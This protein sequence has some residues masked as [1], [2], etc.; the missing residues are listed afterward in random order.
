MLNNTSSYDFQW[1]ILTVEYRHQLPVSEDQ[2]FTCG[3][4]PKPAAQKLFK[5]NLLQGVIVKR[6]ET[7]EKNHC[8]NKTMKRDDC[9]RI[10]MTENKMSQRVKSL[11]AIFSTVDAVTKNTEI[12]NIRKHSCFPKFSVKKTQK[13]LIDQTT[14]DFHKKKFN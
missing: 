7:G 2:L 14:K 10:V 9:F 5:M 3:D 1:P 11:S 12:I 4:F 8:L 6:W 13:W